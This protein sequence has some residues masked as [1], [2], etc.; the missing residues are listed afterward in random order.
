MNRQSNAYRISILAILS[1]IILIQANVPFLGFIPLGFTSLT[2][3]HI[4]VIVAAITLGTRDGAIVGLVWGLATVIRAFVAPTT[5]L[6]TLIFTN[7]LVSVLP[8]ILVGVVAGV[9]FH[10]LYKRTQKLTFSTIVAAA[11]GT[12]TNTVL[13]LTMMGILYTGPVADAYQVAPSGLFKALAIVVG[14]NGVPEII[15]AVIITPLIVTALFKA[16]RLNPPKP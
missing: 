6:D 2:I 10:A 15:G 1:A 5:P 3:I 9:V 11:L 4:T 14:T 7:P 13:V 16:T 12:L 8:R